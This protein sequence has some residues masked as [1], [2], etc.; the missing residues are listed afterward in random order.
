MMT[1]QE[2]KRRQT[3]V[4][5][6]NSGTNNW[7]LIKKT[8]ERLDIKEFHQLG[9]CLKDKKIKGKERRVLYERRRTLGRR[10]DLDFKTTKC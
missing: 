10:Y 7:S 5:V 6:F 1:K 9:V 3:F 8:N 4:E 2:Q